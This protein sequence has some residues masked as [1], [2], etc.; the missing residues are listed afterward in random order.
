MVVAALAVV[1]AATPTRRVSLTASDCEP[2]FVTEVRSVLG[3]ELKATVGA[4]LVDA[5]EQVE[6]A[7]TPSAVAVVLTR[8]GVSAPL[9]VDVSTVD[10]SLR[11]RT[12]ALV[13]AETMAE[14]PEPA[15]VATSPQPP[16][17][18]PAPPPP[19][20][21]LSLALLVGVRSGPTAH[22]GGAFVVEWEWLRWLGVHADLCVV[23]GTVARTGGLVASTMVDA[24]V[25]LDV[26]AALGPV[27]LRVGPGV[28][29]GGGWLQGLPAAERVGGRVVGVMWG[30]QLSTGLS[31]SPTERLLLTAFVDAGF[32]GTQ[33]VGEVFGEAPVILTG[34]MVTAGVGVGWRL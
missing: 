1:A 7:C 17:V 20:G 21:R 22:F 29:A 11:A 2:G 15:V 33:L 27:R 12:V 3:I 13:L 28:R 14:P 4:V 23:S 18:A 24:S 9:T 8:D 32:W 30:P 10:E 25:G 5:R 26:R 31:V 19:P 16:V 6:L 34:L